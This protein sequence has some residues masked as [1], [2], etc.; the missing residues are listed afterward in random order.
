VGQNASFRVLCR[1]WRGFFSFDFLSHHL[2]GGLRSFVPTGLFSIR[3]ELGQLF[4]LNLFLEVVN[5]DKLEWCSGFAEY[6]F[7]RAV[8]C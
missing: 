1:P 7:G 8:Q 3:S 5:L 2:R 6:L 4:S